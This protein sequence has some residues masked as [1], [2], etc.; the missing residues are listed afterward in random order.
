MSKLR[1]MVLAHVALLPALACAQPHADGATIAAK[2]GSQG[3]AACASC[4]GAHGEGNPS[5]G[6]PRLAGLPQGY[7]VTQLEH[8]AAGSR[9]NA[10]MAPMAKQLTEAERAAVAGY[11]AGLP[12]APAV[13][14]PAEIKAADTGAWLAERG[15]WDQNLP[16]CVQCHGPGGIGVGDAFPPLAGQGASYL[17]AQLKAFKA[18]TRPGG[19]DNL[20]ATVAA[21]LSDAD[22]TAV[23]NH[24]AGAGQAPAAATA[25]K[26]RQ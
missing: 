18:H 1:C 13:A 6:F 16:A 4:H 20:M 24:F 25:G 12:G 23:S 9:Q 17:S 7:I 14:T 5:A 21:R 2:G 8:F 11:Y 19:P 3:V 26:E 22:I 15:R 10:V